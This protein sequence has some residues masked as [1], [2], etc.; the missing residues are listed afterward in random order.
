[1]GGKRA[2]T[3]FA[4]SLS[5]LHTYSCKL[6]STNQVS[7]QRIVAQATEA[8]AA[9]VRYACAAHLHACA[10]YLHYP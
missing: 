3:D 2:D 8:R 6:T 1:M 10:L 5:K 4:R 9:T 7:E